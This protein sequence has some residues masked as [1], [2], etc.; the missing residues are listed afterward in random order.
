MAEPRIFS[1]IIIPEDVLHNKEISSLA[2]LVY[3]ILFRSKS[4]QAEDTDINIDGGQVSENLGVSKEE[5][6]LALLELVD[7]K[8]IS[9]LEVA[10]GSI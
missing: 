9:H 10:D 1:A 3:G 5:V 8:Y 2:K 6:D 7:A 4:V